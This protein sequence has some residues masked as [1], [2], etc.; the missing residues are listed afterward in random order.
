MI[1]KSS[2]CDSLGH[3][4]S[5]FMKWFFSKDKH[6]IECNNITVIDF[7]K[8][9]HVIFFDKDL[10][11]HVLVINR[12][13]IPFCKNCNAYDCGHVSFYVYLNQYYRY[14]GDEIDL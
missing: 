7:F 13:G 9:S 11:K 6:S 5:S 1:K 10:K 8:N 4:T 12:D 3:G 14:Y 2:L